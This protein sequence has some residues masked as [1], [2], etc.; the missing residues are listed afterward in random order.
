MAT[1]FDRQLFRGDTLFFLD[2]VWMDVLTKAIF[3][4]PVQ[5]IPPPNASPYSLAGVRIWVTVKNYVPDPDAAAV[6]DLDNQALGGVTIISATQGTFSVTGPA[7]ATIQ[8]PDSPVPLEFDIQLKT[9]TGE[10]YTIE[11]GTLTVLPDITR[12]VS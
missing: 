2:S 8:F 11:R 1:R 5:N 7:Q 10:I 9:A 3:T 6:M 12:A 4:V